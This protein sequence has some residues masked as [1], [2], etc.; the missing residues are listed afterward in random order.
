M[1]GCTYHIG[2]NAGINTIRTEDQ[3]I[4][5]ITVFVQ[6]QTIPGM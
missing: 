5:A 2:K 4:R 1:H 3:T 6:V